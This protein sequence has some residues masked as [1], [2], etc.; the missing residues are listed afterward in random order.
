MSMTSEFKAFVMRGNVL[1]LAIAVVIGAAFGTVVKSFT[2]DVLMPPVGLLLGHTDFSSLYIN[3]SGRTFASYAQAKAAGAPVIGVGAFI[4]N[5]ISFLIIAFAV[6]LLIQ[7]TKRFKKPVEMTTKTC[8]YCASA[9]P[10]AAVRCPLCTS[11]LQTD[12]ALTEKP[13]QPIATDG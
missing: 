5:V 7:A 2:D 6:F 8:P 13:A 10:L 1:D 3:L 4:N 9:I 11:D 12:V